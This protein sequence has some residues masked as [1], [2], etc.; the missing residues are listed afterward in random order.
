[1]EQHSLPSTC[2]S[3]SESDTPR[4][5]RLEGDGKGAVSKATMSSQQLRMGTGKFKR[6][7]LREGPDVENGYHKLA[8]G[9]LL[10]SR[11][12]KVS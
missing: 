1:M 9:R 5:Y 3:A 8:A 4:K 10:M 7:A 11:R 2:N 12:V 6:R